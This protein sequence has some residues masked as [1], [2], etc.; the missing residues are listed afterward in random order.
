MQ[1]LSLCHE[2]TN[3]V[4]SVFSL[5]QISHDQTSKVS[6]FKDEKGEHALTGTELLTSEGAA[7]TAEAVMS[8]GEKL[9]RRRGL[10]RGGGGSENDEEEVGLS[11]GTQNR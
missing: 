8:N 4:T 11:S 9:E 5:K 6:N 3:C 2:I 7:K 10:E 1:I